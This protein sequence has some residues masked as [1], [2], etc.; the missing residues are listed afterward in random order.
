MKTWPPKEKNKKRKH[1]YV[2]F[3]WHFCKTKAH[4][5]ILRRHS[6]F[7]QISTDFTRILSYLARIFTKFKFLDVRLHPCTPASYTSAPLVIITTQSAA[8]PAFCRAAAFERL[9]HCLAYGFPTFLSPCTPSAFR[10][11]SMYPYSMSADK[12]VP[13]QNFNRW[14]CT[15]KIPYHKIFSSNFTPQVQEARNQSQIFNR[16]SISRNTTHRQSYHL[17]QKKLSSY[18]N[19]FECYVKSI[20]Y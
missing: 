4:T 7:T 6:H 5:R 17:I 16:K 9:V 11:M 3:G 10:Q 8:N 1:L 15:P 19:L 12:P 2:D 14:T 13:L 18:S 20:S